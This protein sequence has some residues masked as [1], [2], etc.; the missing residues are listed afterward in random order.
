MTLDPRW[1][2]GLTLFIA[3]L[4]F[5]SGMGSQFTDLGLDAQ[6]LKALMALISIFAGILGIVNTV[7]TG[8]PS[9]DN[10]TGFIVK[11][12]DKPPGQ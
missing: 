12:P 4:N 8:I 1:A 9:K 5:L 3:I 10:K 11:G 2:I 7:L 6:H